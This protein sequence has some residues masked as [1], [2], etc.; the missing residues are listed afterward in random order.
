MS[1]NHRDMNPLTHTE[2]VA[3]P[4]GQD[5]V[6]D[7]PRDKEAATDDFNRVLWYSLALAFAFFVGSYIITKQ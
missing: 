3:S 5:P 1:E 4:P 6:L 2:P 7:S